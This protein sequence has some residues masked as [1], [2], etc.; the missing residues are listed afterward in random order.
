MRGLSSLYAIDL[1]LRSVGC[2]QPQLTELEGF[3]CCLRA[4]S[5]KSKAGGLLPGLFLQQR[6]SGQAAAGLHQQAES[7]MYA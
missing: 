3:L 7:P 5:S 1:N 2:C 4:G 6:E